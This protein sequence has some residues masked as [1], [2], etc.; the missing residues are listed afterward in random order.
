MFVHRRHAGLEQ[1]GI[2]GASVR[3]GMGALAARFHRQRVRR[4][5]I[6]EMAALA[7]SVASRPPI[8]AQAA[9]SRLNAQLTL[10]GLRS[11]G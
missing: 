3:H 4:A 10:P 8:A 7:D 6:C 1:P 11:T 5:S 9:T 2:V